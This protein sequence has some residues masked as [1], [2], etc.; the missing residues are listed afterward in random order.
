MYSGGKQLTVKDDN[1]TEGANDIVKEKS[2]QDAGPVDDEVGEPYIEGNCR[3]YLKRKK[4]YCRMRPTDASSEFCSRHEP[5]A[6][7]VNKT[8]HYHVHT[9]FPIRCT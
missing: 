8:S 5:G 2:G 1:S 6:A 3:Y 4:R 9:K 7:D